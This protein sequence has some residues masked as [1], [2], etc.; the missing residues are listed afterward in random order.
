MK[1]LKKLFVIMLVCISII[2][3]IAFT[4]ANSAVFRQYKAESAERETQED[5]IKEV[6]AYIKGSDAIGQWDEEAVAMV[7]DLYGPIEAAE[8]DDT[9]GEE[10]DE[11]ML[12]EALAMVKEWTGIDVGR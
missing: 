10:I 8:V 9:Y 4:A 1:A 7:E 11:D 5:R 12:S 2:A 3:V 6:A